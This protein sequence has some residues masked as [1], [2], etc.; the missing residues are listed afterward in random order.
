M[1][2]PDNGAQTAMPLFWLRTTAAIRT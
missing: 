2:G 1:D